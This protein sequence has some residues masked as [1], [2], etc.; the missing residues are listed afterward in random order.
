[1]MQETVSPGTPKQQVRAIMIFCLALIV[2][3]VLF[4][5]VILLLHF[6]NGP[7]MDDK[8]PVFKEIMLYAAIGIAVFCF[9]NAMRMFKKLR[10]TGTQLVSLNDRLNQYRTA[11]IVYMAGCEGAAIFSIIAFFM[12]GVP[13]LLI[14]TGLM[15]AAML[16]KFPFRKKII[17][18]LALDWKEQ[19]EL[20]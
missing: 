9:V 8:E 6:T 13:W 16:V 17:A 11:L 2:G 19:Q 4:A 18:D 5:A 15:L 20:E 14:I 3:T 12:T 1:M 10:N 7:V